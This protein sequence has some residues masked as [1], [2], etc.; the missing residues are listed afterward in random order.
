MFLIIGFFLMSIPE[1][2]ETLFSLLYSRFKDGRLFIIYDNCCNALEYALN[3]EPYFFK[4]AVF[5]V[6]GVHWKNHIN[7]TLGKLAVPFHV[8]RLLNLIL[9]IL[10]RQYRS[11]RK[12]ISVDTRY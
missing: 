5:G 7:C 9:S 10:T 8:T 3:R 1:S 12:G 4:D 6:D 11:F 2:A